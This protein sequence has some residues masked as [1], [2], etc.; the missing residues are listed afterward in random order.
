MNTIPKATAHAAVYDCVS[1]G[2]KCGPI[3]RHDFQWGPD[4]T[5]SGTMLTQHA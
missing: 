2:A 4:L 3:I 1:A 5:D